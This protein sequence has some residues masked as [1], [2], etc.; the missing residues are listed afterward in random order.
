MKVENLAEKASDFT[1]NVWHFKENGESTLIDAGTGDSWE[2]VSGL[3]K[4]DKVVVTHSH[5]DHVDNLPKI[6]DKF[7][8]EIYAYEPENL[9][10]EA[11]GISEGDKVLLGGL[12]FEVFHTPG[13]KDDSICLYSS[14]EKILFTGDLIFPEGGFGRTDLDEGDRDLLIESLGKLEGLQVDE[15]FCGHDPAAR[16]DVEEQISRSLKE[17]GKKE[18]KY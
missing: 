13:H 18:P 16:E 11:S 9:P 14:E 5:H 3:E 15:M 1:G 6:V 17:A 10:V 8:P 7:D 2:K 4:V 12:E